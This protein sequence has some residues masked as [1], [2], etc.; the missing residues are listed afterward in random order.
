MPVAEVL[1]IFQKDEDLP[2]YEVFL[3]NDDQIFFG[4]VDETNGSFFTL[5]EEEWGKV[6]AFVDEQ[7]KSI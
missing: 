5:S 7:F 6:K 3:N 4:N 1:N 2:K